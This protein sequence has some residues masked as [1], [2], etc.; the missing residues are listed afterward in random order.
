MTDETILDEAKR[1]TEKDRQDDYGHPAV[2]H[3]VIGDL[4]GVVLEASKWAKG[5]PVPAALVADMM[6][7]LKIARNQHKRKRDNYVDVAGYAHCGYRIAELDSDSAAAAAKI[8][9]GMK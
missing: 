9:E 8:L 2:E 3:K 1:I 6:I 5:E 4:W 7:L